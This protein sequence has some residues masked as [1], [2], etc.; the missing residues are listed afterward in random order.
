MTDTVVIVERR[1]GFVS[2]TASYFFNTL[3]IKN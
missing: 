3:S 2:S 1:T